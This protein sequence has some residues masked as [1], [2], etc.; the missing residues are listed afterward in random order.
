MRFESPLDERP[1]D[2]RLQICESGSHLREWRFES[3]IMDDPSF[4]LLVDKIDTAI[5]HL[6]VAKTYPWISKVICCRYF[7]SMG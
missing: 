2:G 4:V 6:K 1:S 3:L 5:G 7:P